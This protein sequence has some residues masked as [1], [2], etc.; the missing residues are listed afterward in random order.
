MEIVIAKSP[1]KIIFR[2]NPMLGRAAKTANLTLY[3]IKI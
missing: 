1:A 2:I 3:E